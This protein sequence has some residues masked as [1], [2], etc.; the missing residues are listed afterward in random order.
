M[1]K[2]KYAIDY[3]EFSKLPPQNMEME[4]A[5]LGCL[6]MDNELINSIMFLK[7]DAFYNMKNRALYS[8]MLHMH[9]ESEEIDTLTL[10]DKHKK[11]SEESVSAYEIATLLN[12]ACA[13]SL[14]K[15]YALILYEKYILRQIIMYSMT[16]SKHAYEDNIEK[17]SA[18]IIALID[19]ME[20]INNMGDNVTDAVTQTLE[21]IKAR[22]KGIVNAQLLTGWS[23]YDDLLK[24]DTSRLIVIAAGQ[25][26]G[27]TAFII[28]QIKK[29]FEM[30]K[31][32]AVQ[33]YSFEMSKEAVIRR[34]I[35]EDVGLTENQI[36][37]KG[38]KL[39]QSDIDKIKK[40][41]ATISSYN[42]QII[43]Y[44]LSIYDIRKRFKSFCKKNIGKQ[45]ICVIDNHGFLADT[46]EDDNKVSKL[47][48]T[49]RDETKSLI[50]VLH[51]LTTKGNQ[52]FNVENGYEPNKEMVRGSTRIIDYCN[53]LVLLHRPDFFM[54]LMQKLK[55]ECTPEEY[56]AIK[57]LFLGIV[58]IN[59]EGGTGYFRLQHNIKYNQ[60]TQ[61][62]LL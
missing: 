41:T 57:S 55:L 24:L 52:L 25:K 16:A 10:Y 44:K 43:D 14:V 26:I 30:N 39:N 45:C 33:W 8:T 56:N 7:P 51:H 49:I 2:N 15:Q 46:I 17:A 31:N 32:I 48:A 21:D 53:A 20:Q 60:F 38:Y 42:I 36:Q 37:S 6:I 58:P 61:F 9:E 40:S 3:T 34:M 29:I 19:F 28:S 27:K 4:E 1:V 47:Y 54:D 22:H 59:R 50:F 12:K 23:E 11:I 13:P 35:M 62:Q 18:E 5:L